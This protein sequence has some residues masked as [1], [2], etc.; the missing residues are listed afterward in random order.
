MSQAD[1][2]VPSGPGGS[3][4]TGIEAAIAAANSGHSGSSDPTYKVAGMGWWRTDVPGSGVWTWYEYDGTNKIAVYTLNTSTHVLTSVAPLGTAV[5]D[6]Y[7]QSAAGV[8]TQTASYTLL[9]SDNG[10]TVVINDASAANVT[11]PS[12]LTAGFSCTVVQLGAGQVTVVQGSG[13]TLHAANGLKTN[14]QYSVLGI[15][16]VA[17]DTYIVAGDA[18]T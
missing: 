3:V 11:V 9:N 6:A 7:T 2:A 12:G 14:K 1:P 4:R 18:S 5:A 16:Y 8:D 10:K 15:V 17:A 13:A